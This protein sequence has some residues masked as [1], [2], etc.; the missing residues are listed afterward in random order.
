[1]QPEQWNREIEACLAQIKLRHRP[2]FETLYRL[3]SARLYGLTLKIISDRELAADTLQE[4]YAKIWNN[5][6]A[7]RSDLGGGWAWICQ[8]SRNNAIDRVRQI[9]RQ[10][11][12]LDDS[13]IDQLAGD[14][15]GLWQQH[16]D[17][18]RCLQK[19]REEPRVAILSSYIHGLTH[20]E[21]SARLQVPLGTLKSWIRR[22]LKELH[23][24]LE[25]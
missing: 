20:A 15:S 1:M 16:H 9:Q 23:Q 19:I 8:L 12:Q 6:D 22:G 18:S 24:C 3:T 4:S 21:L 13:L 17:L 14:E 11:E 7:Y 2:A 25:A 10:P 5:A